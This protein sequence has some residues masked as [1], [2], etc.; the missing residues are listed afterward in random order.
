MYCMKE[1]KVQDTIDFTDPRI[2][3]LEKDIERTNILNKELKIKNLKLEEQAKIYC[4][5]IDEYRSLILKI[6]R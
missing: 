3:I 4:S 2:N 1:G 5:I 6:K